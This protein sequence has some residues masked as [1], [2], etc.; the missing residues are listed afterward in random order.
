MPW[1]N[2]GLRL[3]ATHIFNSNT[4][5]GFKMMLFEAS[6]AITKDT[7]T[8]G[9]VSE[10]D[11]GNGYTT[12]GFDVPKNSTGFPSI[13]KDNDLDKVLI[14]SLEASWVPTGRLPVTGGIRYTALTTNEATIADRTILYYVDHISDLVVNVGT[15]FKSKQTVEMSST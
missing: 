5:T 6:P 4:F 3:A 10:I 14:Q 8:V 7:T 13:T 12:G 2:E 9:T 11:N 1:T 15:T